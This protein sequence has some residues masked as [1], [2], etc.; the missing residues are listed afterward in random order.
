M[1]LWGTDDNSK[2]KIAADNYQ[3]CDLGHKIVTDARIDATCTE[4]GLTEGAHCSRCGTVIVKQEVIPATGVHQYV[5]TVCSSCGAIGGSC[6]ADLNWSLDEGVLTISGT[7]MMDDYAVKDPDAAEFTN[8]W[9]RYASRIT[10]IVIADSVTSVGD[11]AFAGCTGVQM[12]IMPAGITTL[13]N[14][15]VF[16]G[17]LCLKEIKFLGS[18][19]A[20]GL[21]TFQG[22]TATVFYPASDVSWM[23]VV[24]QNYGGSITWKPDCGGNHR[25]QTD[26]KIAPTCTETGLTEGSHC[27]AC[28]Q[29]LK[30]QQIIPALGHAYQDKLVAPTCTTSGYTAHFCEVCGDQYTDQTVPALGHTW[31]D[32]TCTTPK[33]CGICNQQEGAL[34][35]HSYRDDWD[36]ACDKCG[37]IRKLD[38]TLTPMYRLYNPYTQEHLLTSN[39]AEKEQLISVGWHFDGVAW[40]T[41]SKGEPVYRLYNPFDDWHTYSMSLEEIDML[42]PLGWK[43]DGVV[44]YSAAGNTDTPIFRLF[45]PYAQVNYHLLTASEEEIRWLV[46]LGWILEGVGWYGVR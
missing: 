41:P 4:T 39:Q 20:L 25:A 1:S 43:V 33:T 27:S 6:G 9:G 37:H 23:E 40:M 31:L 12:V 14:T 38:I 36:T 16:S 3:S 15:G 10:E 11:Y 2:L 35:P 24:T 22:V 13:G 28:G 21:E 29:I 30:A 44:C 18:A 45:N 19:P 5:D 42:I 46:S 8:P 32:A 26:A 34:L 17:C 7:G